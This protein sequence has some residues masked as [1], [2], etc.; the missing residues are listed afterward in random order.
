[1]R[2]FWPGDNESTS[3]T[4]CRALTPASGQAAASVWLRPGGFPAILPAAT[5]RDSAKDPD[6]PEITGAW[7]YTSSPALNPETPGPADSTTPE[8]SP[9]KVNGGGTGIICCK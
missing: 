7:P 1:M 3:L 6:P 9:P 5:I 4:A 2:T 8:K